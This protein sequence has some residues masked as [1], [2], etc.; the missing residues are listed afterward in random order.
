[1]IGDK[2]LKVEGYM[3][4]RKV[5]TTSA[6]VA[7]RAKGRDAFGNERQRDP[8][9]KV[10]D[11]EMEEKQKRERTKIYAKKAEK[12]INEKVTKELNTISMKG[13]I[14]NGA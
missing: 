9:P 2:K 8:T 4:S 12:F 11:K 13:V 10:V 3:S 7:A 5:Y 6:L 14:R 1:M